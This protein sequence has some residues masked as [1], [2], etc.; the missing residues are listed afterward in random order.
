MQQTAT[1]GCEEDVRS[2]S[3]MY[4]TVAERLPNKEA[5]IASSSGFLSLNQSKYCDEGR[6]IKGKIPYK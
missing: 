3:L 2:I 6:F 5:K 1:N 4:T